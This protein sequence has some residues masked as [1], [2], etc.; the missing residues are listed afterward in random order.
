MI[1]QAI[2]LT[3]YNQGDLISSTNVAITTF[4]SST[5]DTLGKYSNFHAPKA[6]IVWPFNQLHTGYTK[7]LKMRFLAQ[8]LNQWP[9]MISYNSIYYFVA[10]ILKKILWIKPWFN[11][12]KKNQISY[13]KMALVCK[14]LR[15][16]ATLLW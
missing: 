9:V 4:T 6:L 10:F 5:K 16:L 14:Y 7:F 15:R 13:T 8:H 3:A 2:L 12:E 11:V 1:H